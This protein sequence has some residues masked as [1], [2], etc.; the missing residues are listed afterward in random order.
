M[1]KCGLIFKSYYFRLSSNFSSCVTVVGKT[2]YCCVQRNSVFVSRYFKKAETFN[3]KK[4]LTSTELLYVVYHVVIVTS[5]QVLQYNKIFQRAPLNCKDSESCSIH[6]REQQ[7]LK[8]NF[9]ST[10]VVKRGQKV[11]ELTSRLRS[12]IF[13]QEIFLMFNDYGECLLSKCRWSHLT[14]V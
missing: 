2:R 4:F 8:T 5:T 14:K 13:I 1:N 6:S 12:A 7:I 11:C 3:K 9:A 10:Q